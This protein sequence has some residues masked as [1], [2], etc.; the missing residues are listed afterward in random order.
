MPKRDRIMPF[1]AYQLLP[2]TN[3][4]LCSLPGCF[5]FAAALIGREKGLKDCPELKKDEYRHL[6]HKLSEYF[7]EEVEEV[8]RSGLLINKE[9]C[10]GCGDCV[11]VC[12]KSFT[13][14]NLGQI[15]GGGTHGVVMHGAALDE[16]SP[17]PVLEVVDGVLQ[18]INWSGCKRC[19]EA[20]SFCRICEEKCPLGAL[21]LVRKGEEASG[22]LTD[23]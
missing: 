9:R 16:A 7:G 2:R 8:A 13:S 22:E 11:V 18:V 19:S 21:E 20:A 15:P 6:L 23:F 4:K 17:L 12:N 14:V 5:A 1:Q 3:C 10:N